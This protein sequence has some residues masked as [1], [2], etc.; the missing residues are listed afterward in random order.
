MYSVI[1]LAALPRKVHRLGVAKWEDRK[2]WTAL[3]AVEDGLAWVEGSGA[4]V[5][6]V[7]VDGIQVKVGLEEE[8]DRVDS[9]YCKQVVSAQ[10]NM[11]VHLHTVAF[12]TW[13]F[14]VL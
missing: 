2:A 6:V 1:G 12:G 4:V 9:S 13:L 5:A 11:A 8:R 3:F 10:G 7:A 14:V